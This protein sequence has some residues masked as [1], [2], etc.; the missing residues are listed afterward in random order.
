MGKGDREGQGTHG[1]KNKKKA[2]SLSDSNPAMLS[3]SSLPSLPPFASVQYFVY[4]PELDPFHTPNVRPSVY[5]AEL[6]AVDL[7][8]A[9]TIKGF[10]GQDWT[11]VMMI[12][13]QDLGAVP[14]RMQTRFKMVGSSTRMSE[15]LDC[16]YGGLCLVEESMCICTIAW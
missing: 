16:R 3:L 4:K 12:T 6:P 11:F 7:D 1:K 2:P 5:F 14:F 13:A 10:F 9:K 8:A 15:V